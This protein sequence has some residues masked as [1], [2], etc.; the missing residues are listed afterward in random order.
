MTTTEVRPVAVMAG[1]LLALRADL[2][3]VHDWL[4]IS[5]P[6]DLPPPQP[7]ISP[8]ISDVAGLVTLTVHCWA[9]GQFARAVRLLVAAVGEVDKDPV[10]DH[11]H[12]VGRFGAVEFRVVANRDQVCTRRQVGTTTEMQRDPSAPMVEVE[13]PVY[14]WDCEPVLSAEREHEAMTSDDAQPIDGATPFAEQAVVW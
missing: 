12:V 9:D 4:T 6:D 10:G 3:K 2:A 8:Q 7:G 5:W 1:R 13:V 11:M 14:A